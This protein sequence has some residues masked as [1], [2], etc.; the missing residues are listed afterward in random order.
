MLN[1]NN[2]TFLSL[3]DLC[4]CV[5]K[6]AWPTVVT[7]VDGDTAEPGGSDVEAQRVPVG[8][9]ARGAVR[10]HGPARVLQRWRSYV[11]CSQDIQV[12]LQRVKACQGNYLLS[13]CNGF[14]KIDIRV[15]RFFAH[16]LIVLS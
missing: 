9:C 16:V 13:C 7:L 12:R 8:P 2:L 3:N 10:R 5:S 4:M 1:C 11:E 6:C 14:P 15:R